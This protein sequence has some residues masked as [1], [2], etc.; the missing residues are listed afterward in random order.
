MTSALSMVK[1]LLF[2][3]GKENGP[4][5]VVKLVGPVSDKIA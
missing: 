3:S 4:W 1:N 5:A 2:R